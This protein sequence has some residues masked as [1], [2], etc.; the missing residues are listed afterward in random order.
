[1]GIITQTVFRFVFGETNK[2]SDS[3]RTKHGNKPNKVFK[4]V[5]KK[6][7]RAKMRQALWVGKEP[8]EFKKS[9]TWDWN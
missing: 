7:R 9:D 5:Q 3:Y 2:V 6:K 8:P 4:V 1:M